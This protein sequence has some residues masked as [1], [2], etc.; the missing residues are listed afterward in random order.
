M[1]H[2]EDHQGYIYVQST[3]GN[4]HPIIKLSFLARILLYAI[5]GEWDEIWAAGRHECNSM[6]MNKVDVLQCGRYLSLGIV[7]RLP[8][9]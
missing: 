9:E 2:S 1:H 6:I 7:S 4:S 5:K 8:C 3:S